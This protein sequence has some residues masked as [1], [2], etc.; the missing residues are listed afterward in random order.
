MRS[1]PTRQ[2]MEPVQRL[3]CY[4]L[5]VDDGQLLLCRLSR[6]V[7]PPGSWTLPG[8][9]VEFGEHP[10]DAVIRE[11]KEETGFDI[12]LDELAKIDSMVYMRPG[13]PRH[14]IRLVFH[15]HI[16]GGKM[17]HE[18]DGS[19]EECRWVTPDQARTMQL[20]DLAELGMELALG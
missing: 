2:K 18:K 6:H 12:E 20:V 7:R 14:A 9:G 10:E 17:I 11:V 1:R 4:A 13:P 16:V 3:A 19:T 5:I 8:G 15:A